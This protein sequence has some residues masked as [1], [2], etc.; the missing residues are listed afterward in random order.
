MHTVVLNLSVSIVIDDLG[1]S[2]RGRME[3]HPQSGGHFSV[4][5]EVTERVNALFEFLRIKVSFVASETV[6]PQILTAS[7]R[8]KFVENHTGENHDVAFRLPLFAMQVVWLVNT[9][10]MSIY[11]EIRQPSSLEEENSE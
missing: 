10:D 4:A 2:G 6:T 3:T 5:Q 1:T 9:F 11:N 8:V 7:V